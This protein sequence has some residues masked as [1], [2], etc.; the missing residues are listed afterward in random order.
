M[1]NKICTGCNCVNGERATYCRQCG[2]SLDDAGISEVEVSEVTEGSASSG[3]NGEGKKSSSGTAA[4]NE[5]QFNVPKCP[6]KPS[7]IYWP[8][9]LSLASAMLMFVLIVYFVFAPESSRPSAP[10][11]N[12]PSAPP[13]TEPTETLPPPVDISEL[14][15]A[16]I[17]DQTYTGD[18][19]TVDFGLNHDGYDLVEGTDY[20][21]TYE[22]NLVIGTASAHI[23]GIGDRFTGSC[24]TTFNILTG[25][26]VCDDPENYGVVIFS[27]RLSWTMISRS[28]TLDELIDQV[29]RLKDGEVTGSGL[30]NEVAFS[31]EA[32]SLNFT[33]A[34][35]VSA[36]Y[37]GVLARP[38]DQEGLDYN[39]SLL[40]GGMSR[41]DL[42][43]G[44]ISVPDGE[45]ENICNSLGIIPA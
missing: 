11:G 20:Q 25:D 34:E 29:H 4:G 5:D 39:V 35:F 28:P 13:A 16:E 38:A 30:V 19:V 32:L 43:N 26:P 10:G 7:V 36:F 24:D 14:T 41:Q 1:I 37:Q 40:E 33:D 12:H 8:F 45:F 27:M 31:E 17:P 22:N 3:T 15:I 23:E 2:A 21:V 6:A 44:I 18:A 42:A 9:V